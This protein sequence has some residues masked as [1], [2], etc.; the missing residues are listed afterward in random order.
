MNK[1]FENLQ[2]A[3]VW[4]FFDE[5]LTIPRPSKHEEKISAYL[6]KFGHDRQ[7]ETLADEV[8]NVLIRK[9][10]H[11]GYEN[12]PGV[13]LQAHMD[14]VC[15]KNS[16]KEFT[17]M[18]DAIQP[19]RDGEW[20]TAD[21]T[22]LGADD[23]I[24]VATILAILDDKTI[25]HGPLEALFTV[26]EET[27][28]TGANAL[29]TDWLQSQIL[30][31]FDDEDEGE[32][33][34]GCAGGIDTTVDIDFHPTPVD[35][36]VEA[37]K[38]HVRGL[39]GGHSGDDINKGLGCANKMLNR[40]L[41][42]GTFNLGLKISYI[43]GGNL[44]NAIAREAYAIV[45]VDKS[46]VSALRKMVADYEEHLRFEFRSTEPDLSISIEGAE[47]PTTVMDEA[48][49]QNL[50]NALYACAHGVLAMSREI[51]NFVETSTNLASI[52]MKENHIHI[53]TSQRSSVESAKRAAAEKIEAT[54][55]LMGAKVSHSDGYPGW[56]PNPESRV[57]KVA[58]DV[59]KRLFHHD[60]VV[61]A[62]HAGL[63]CGLIGEK[64]PQ[65]D[66]ISYGPTLRGVHSPDER[67]EIKTVQMFWDD[68]MAI[69]KELR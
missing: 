42:N 29:H 57:L 44:R 33:C 38:I 25:E 16:D 68:T 23:G 18:T 19:I 40:I 24:G 56:T 58:V 22:T 46:N 13:C 3:A 36:N 41:W 15:E 1:A 35:A 7:L 5:I 64:Y 28:L 27:G 12:A 37:F 69:L 66:M 20:I 10:A 61:R 43:D 63:E 53:A 67:L 48:T 11:P 55:L 9:P 62:I 50:V 32:F 47:T 54:F 2:P 34:I 30:L 26:D 17:F 49:Q 4:H 52:K 6:Q 39:K 45:T 8:G 31:N 65:M 59:Y 21:G 51:P 14:M 60:P